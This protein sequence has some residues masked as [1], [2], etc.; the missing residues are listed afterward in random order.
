[1][2]FDATTDIVNGIKE[3]VIN[4]TVAQREY[5]MGYKSVELILRMVVE[6]DDTAFEAMSVV[7]GVIDTGVDVITP[8]TLKDY[9]A[10]LD[11]KGIPHEW[12][13]EGWEAPE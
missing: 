7:D 1:V 4:A 10:S 5:D 2:C 6:G 9:E 13:T 8:A 3:G 11:T 12:N